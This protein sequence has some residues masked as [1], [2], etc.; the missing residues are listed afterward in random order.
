[1]F[2][3]LLNVCVDARFFACMILTSLTFYTLSLIKVQLYGSDCQWYYDFIIAVTRCLYFGMDYRNI[4]E[5]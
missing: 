1:M 2:D 3:F 5:L 4:N